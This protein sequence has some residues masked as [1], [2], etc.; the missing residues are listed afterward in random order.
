MW[1]E[2]VPKLFCELLRFCVKLVLECAGLFAF[3]EFNA[4]VFAFDRASYLCEFFFWIELVVF[5]L[6]LIT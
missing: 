4:G 2:D 5:A 3:Y 6:T 1:H